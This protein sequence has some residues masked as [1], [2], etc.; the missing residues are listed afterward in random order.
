MPGTREN[1]VH[2]EN[3]HGEALEANLAVVLESGTPVFSTESFGFSVGVRF[4]EA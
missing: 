1:D 2:D 3:A 4:T